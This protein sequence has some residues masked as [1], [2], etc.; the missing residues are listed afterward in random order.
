MPGS[1]C[2]TTTTTV[3]AGAGA[4]GAASPPPR[5]STNV[6]LVKT[7]MSM[8]AIA[9]STVAHHMAPRLCAG[10]A[11]AEAPMLMVVL[12]RSSILLCLLWTRARCF[13]WVLCMGVIARWPERPLPGRR[14]SL[15]S[16]P[17]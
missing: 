7:S 1:R 13:S 10:G 14:S 11:T 6:M 17:R 2:T 8:V 5:D 15:R 9:L 3:T 4:A 12:L 16:A